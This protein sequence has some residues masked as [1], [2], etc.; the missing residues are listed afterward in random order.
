[1][2]IATKQ[3]IDQMLDS[4]L[5]DIKNELLQAFDQIGKTKQRMTLDEVAENWGITKPYASKRLKEAY[6]AGDVKTV[7]FDNRPITIEREE[8]FNYASNYKRS[9]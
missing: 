5:E 3:E 8:F 7:D 1:M 6:K 2:E 4:K 9:Q